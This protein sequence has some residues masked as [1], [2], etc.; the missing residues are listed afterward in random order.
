MKDSRTRMPRQSSTV[1]AGKALGDMERRFRSIMDSMR[2]TDERHRRAALQHP[3][4]TTATELI[5]VPRTKVDERINRMLREIG[6][7]T[8][9]DRAFVL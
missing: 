3:I 8:N 4:M 5:D 7:F 1:F 2:K 6:I 9:F